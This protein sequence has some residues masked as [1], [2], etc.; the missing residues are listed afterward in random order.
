MII[1]III[2]IVLIVVIVIVLVLYKVE[3]INLEVYQHFRDDQI[4]QLNFKIY[5]TKKT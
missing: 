3:R 5:A 2:V 4:E 1:N